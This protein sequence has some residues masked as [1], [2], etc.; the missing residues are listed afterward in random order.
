MDQI[1]LDLSDDDLVRQWVLYR[2][3]V[4]QMVP[5]AEDVLL[6]V[7]LAQRLAV[8]EE[9]TLQEADVRLYQQLDQVSSVEVV[10]ELLGVVLVAPCLN[11]RNDESFLSPHTIADQRGEGAPAD[12]LSL[13]ALDEAVVEVGL[14]GG[15]SP[16]L[17]LLL[18]Q[19]QQ[20]NQYLVSLQ[21]IFYLRVFL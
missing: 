20:L 21:G 19:V 6:V 10:V 18:A 2:Q 9:D 11:P 3:R 8:V 5:T 15:R 4:V 12:A 13:L 14:I 1:E 16:V 7:F 17:S